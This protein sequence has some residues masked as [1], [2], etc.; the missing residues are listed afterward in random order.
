MAC[1]SNCATQDHASYGECLRDKG[2]QIDKHSLTVSDRLERRKDH[3]L[4]RFREC[5]KAGVIPASP[6]KSDVEKAE[7]QLNANRR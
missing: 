7:G 2:I 5:A 4:A 1:A 3:T 6:L